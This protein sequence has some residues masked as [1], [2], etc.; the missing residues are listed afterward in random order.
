M[1]SSL[2]SERGSAAHRVV[3]I[4][5]L[6]L[7]FVAAIGAIAVFTFAVTVDGHSMDPT[8]KT[9]DRLSANM[10]AKDDVERFDLVEAAEPGNGTHIVKRV[11][12]MP[13]DTIWVSTSAAGPSVYVQPRGDDTTYL[14]ENPTW[15][16]QLGSS[17]TSC[18]DPNG[19][20]SDQPKK[21]TVPADRFWVIGDNWGGSTDS[22][23]FGWVSA[24]EIKATL[25]F[26]VLPFSRFGAVPVPDGL[27]LVAQD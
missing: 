14:V 19:A 1:N 16:A 3:G 11:I 9:G 4:G 10:F 18:C 27:A 22:R 7:F 17:L 2:R 25:N 21:A 20:A 15:P 8:L 26:R 12:G 23:A 13:G 6:V 5:A 24:D